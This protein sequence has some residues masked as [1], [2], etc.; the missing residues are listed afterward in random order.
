MSSSIDLDRVTQALEAVA[1]AQ[2]HLPDLIRCD[3]EGEVLG[4]LVDV[5]RKRTG[6]PVAWAVS[7]TGDIQRGD[8]SFDALATTGGGTVPAP[9]EVSRTV[10]GWVAR[11]ARPAWADEAAADERFGAARSIVIHDLRSVG[12]VP[13]GKRGALYVADPSAAGRFGPAERLALP[14]LCALAAPF[15]DRR[16]AVPQ[17]PAPEPLPGLVG[18]SGAM[19]A[20]CRAVRAFAPMPASRRTL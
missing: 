7:W 18:S 17:G 6:A 14:A 2:G 9:S 15:L 1:W 16:A 8:L 10:L 4:L 20:L 5:A 11:E 3:G 13:I 19:F 12:C